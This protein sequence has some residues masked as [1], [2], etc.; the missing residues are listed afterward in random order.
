[1]KRLLFLLCIAGSLFAE[2]IELK[3]KVAEKDIFIGD[4]IHISCILNGPERMQF[5]LPDAGRHIRDLEILEQ[6]TGR[7]TEKKRQILRLELE[8]TAFDTGFMYIPPLPV[9]YDNPADTGKQDTLYFPERYI[10]F[11]S[12][13]DTSVAPVAMKAPV[14]LS[15]MT[16]WEYLITAVLLALA[17]ILLFYG[18]RRNKS[19]KSKK[20]YTSWISSG[21]KAAYAISELQSKN[22]PEERRWKEFYLELSYILREYFENIYFLHLH[23]LSTSEILPALRP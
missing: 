22:Y 15:L 20:E 16:W 4:R 1:M 8:A 12:A 17:V 23:E 14:P 6:N 3:L 10:Y 19:I 21:E 13:L 9:L 18:L 11:R 2:D 7:R 5:T